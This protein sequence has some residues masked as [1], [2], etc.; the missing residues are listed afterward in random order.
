M[1]KFKMILLSFAMMLISTINVFAA[2]VE[3]TDDMIM[4]SYVQPG[5]RFSESSKLGRP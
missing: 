5:E 1:K 3:T 2:N 4:R